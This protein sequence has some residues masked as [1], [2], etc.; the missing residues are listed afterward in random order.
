MDDC[1]GEWVAADIVAAGVPLEELD[2]GDKYAVPVSTGEEAV[3]V[4]HVDQGAAFDTVLVAHVESDVVFHVELPNSFVVS[5]WAAQEVAECK[6]VLMMCINRETVVDNS[7][8]CVLD[9]G[10]RKGVVKGKC[11]DPSVSSHEVLAV[12]R[13]GDV[14]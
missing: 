4:G 8:W 7:R 1:A 6:P 12:Y 14:R 2:V 10:V 5:E 9:N 11:M 3:A 13:G